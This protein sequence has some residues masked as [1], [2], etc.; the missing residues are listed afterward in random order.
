[1]CVAIYKPGDKSISKSVLRQCWTKNP[2]GAGF[3]YADNGS[4]IVEKGLMD[5]HSFWKAYKNALYGKAKGMDMVIHFRIGTSGLM[6]ENNCHPHIVSEELAFVHNG[7]ISELSFK[8]SDKSDTIHF[9]ERY[10]N[11]FYVSMGL[12]FLNQEHIVGLMSGYIGHSKLIFMGGDGVTHIINEEMGS[13]KDGNWYSNL[14]W[15]YTPIV[16]VKGYVN[17]GYNYGRT[18]EY[19][20]DSCPSTAGAIDNQ[21]DFTNATARGCFVDG[22]FISWEDY[23]KAWPAKGLD[24][25]GTII[26]EKKHKDSFDSKQKKRTE[27]LALFNADDLNLYDI[28]HCVDC[29]VPLKESEILSGEG[30][31]VACCIDKTLNSEWRNLK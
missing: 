18:Y 8:D 11:P 15:N 6:D 21:P 16:P 22:K 2:D 13:W 30:M 3:M 12:D 1:M 14:Q 10:V 20:D 24:D 31:C 25:T 17:Y 19:N 29:N 27:L 5:F 7:I 9:M 4:V 26:S 23:D 28:G